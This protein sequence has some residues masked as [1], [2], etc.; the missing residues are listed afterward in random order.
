MTNNKVST[1]T[2]ICILAITIVGLVL[3]QAAFWSY[4][5]DDAYITYRY[6]KNLANGLG[7]VFNEGERV[8]G[9]TN[10]LWLNIL[11]GFYKL[12]ADIV[13]TSKILGAAS[14]I[15]V[16]VLTYLMVIKYY[17]S[18]NFIGLLPPIYLASTPSFVA[19]SVSGLETTLFTLLLTAGML[20]FVT[21]S[22]KKC[23]FPWSAIFM[24]LAGMTRPEGVL[25]FFITSLFVICRWS[26]DKSRVTYDIHWFIAFFIIAIPYMTWRWSYFGYFLPNTF[27]AKTGKGLIQFLGGVLYTT[28]G[29]RK[30]GGLLFF[31]VALLPA[32]WGPFKT[33]GKYFAAVIVVFM[34]YNIYKGHDVLSLF[35][36]FVPILPVLYGMVFIALRL[37]IKH[38]AENVSSEAPLIVLIGVF[39]V[40]S[41]G[42]N[43]VLSYLSHDK[44]IELKE[45]QLQLRI[46][47]DEFID[48]AKRLM[49]IAPN[50]ATIAL[51]DAGVISYMTGWYII[52]RWGLCDEH[53]AHVK[54]KGPLGEKYDE[55][56]VLSKK[57]IFIQTKVTSEMEESGRLHLGWAGDTELFNNRIFQNDYVRLEDPKLRTFF[58]R[59]DFHIVKN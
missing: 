31:L 57:P 18:N 41:L 3:H 45:Y 30:H 59:K 28:A 10:F 13:I 9:Y 44:R 36:F 40:V 53:I 49:E 42:T 20:F 11:S 17:G 7:F 39:I 8:E 12:G 6:S 48:Y 51:V 47:D 33:K 52:D 27:Y 5:V 21:E 38:I 50:G 2:I 29:I 23:P 19:W 32:I 24:V 43:A 15:L 56:Y 54:G 34:F 25:L 46:D 26:S 55:E 35:R 58:I 37:L 16:L 1:R 14:G 4:T 22:E